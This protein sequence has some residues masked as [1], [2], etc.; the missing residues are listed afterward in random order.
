MDNKNYLFCF[1]FRSLPLAALFNLLNLTSIAQPVTNNVISLGSGSTVPGAIAKHD[2]LETELEFYPF[3]MIVPNDPVIKNEAMFDYHKFSKSE[4]TLYGLRF[5]ADANTHWMGTRD[6][7]DL[8]MYTEF[9]YG[10]KHF[11]IGA[12]AGSVTAQEYLSL[13]PQYV[14]YD[15]RL[16]RRAAIVSRVAPDFVLGYEFTTQEFDFLDH[17]KISSTG[18]GRMVFPSYQTV[19]QASIW[20]SFEKLKGI[21]FGIEYEYNSAKFY[22]N[23]KFETN[24]E[25]FFGIKAELH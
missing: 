22:N 19:V 16:F 11:Q 25:L 13:G 5:F 18:M 7:K 14:A 9:Y 20:T 4:N 10:L 2:N 15:S 21:Y 23:F 6:M 3:N 24:S 17:V 12:E 8:I 1:V